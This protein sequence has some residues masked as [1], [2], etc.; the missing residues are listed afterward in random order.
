MKKTILTILLI[1]LCGMSFYAQ[2][3]GFSDEEYKFISQI[4]DR[5]TDSLTIIVNKSIPARIL[6]KEFEPMPPFDGKIWVEVLKG[7]IPSISEEIIEDFN[8]NNEKAH[9][10]KRKFT[11]AGKYELVSE[12]RINKIFKAGGWK[13]L[14]ETYP[15]SN[16]YIRFSRVGFNKDKTRALIYYET[17]CGSE[18][19]SG[20]YGFFVKENGKWIVEAAAPLWIS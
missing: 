15:K 1:A 13:A 19:G 10:L 11:F 4:P 12:S 20:N 14:E 7:F 5:S 18:C 16:G 17:R 8:S 9:L 3:K 6:E 2:E